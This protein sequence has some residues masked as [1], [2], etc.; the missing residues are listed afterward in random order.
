MRNFVGD[1]TQ[2]C[3]WALCRKQIPC[4]ENDQNPGCMA[5]LAWNCILWNA[6]WAEFEWEEMETVWP[7]SN[8]NGL[9]PNALNHIIDR[10][11]SYLALSLT[12]LALLL[13]S[14][15]KSFKFISLL[16]EGSGIPPASHDV[17]FFSRRVSSAIKSN[18]NGIKPAIML[19][20]GKITHCHKWIQLRWNEQNSKD[21]FGQMY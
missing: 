4:S 9:R 14:T 2:F 20:P 19:R 5:Y 21:R 7:P 11:S 13:G 18:S 1:W 12:D 16:S 15:T 3:T 6:L 8:S 17:L 10:I